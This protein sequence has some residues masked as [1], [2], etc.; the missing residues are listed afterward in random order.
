MIMSE[1]AMIYSF[2]YAIRVVKSYKISLKIRKNEILTIKIYL[3][4]SLMKLVSYVSISAK[5]DMNLLVKFFLVEQIELL[6]H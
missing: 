5:F 1:K 2:L 6:L 3:N 4:I